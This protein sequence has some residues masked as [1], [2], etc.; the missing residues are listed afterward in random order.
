MRLHSATKSELLMIHSHFTTGIRAEAAAGRGA[1]MID[2]FVP[3][4]SSS[5]YLS[6][7]TTYKRELGRVPYWAIA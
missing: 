5:T 3:T 2:N 7:C 4:Q 6:T 1:G